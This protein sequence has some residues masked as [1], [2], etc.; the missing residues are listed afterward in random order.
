ML[1]KASWTRPIPIEVKEIETGRAFDSIADVTRA[2][3]KK[4]DD[5][6]VESPLTGI[7][8]GSNAAPDK[9]STASTEVQ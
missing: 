2:L 6:L 3:K 5:L 4:V 8:E 1:E 7:T 9:T